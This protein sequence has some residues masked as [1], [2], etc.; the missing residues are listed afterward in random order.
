MHQY[1]KAIGFGN[2]R[3]RKELRKLLGDVEN[4]FTHQTIVSYKP[5][6][7]FCEYQKA[8]GEYMGITVC[9][10]LDEEEI[11]DAAYYFPYFEG[12]GITTYADVTIE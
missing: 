3:T 7:D 10:E 11:F 8:Y 1:L 9:G 12:S 2:I 4:R 5:G 6:E